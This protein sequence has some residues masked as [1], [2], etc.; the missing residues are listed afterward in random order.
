MANTDEARTDE[1]DAPVRATDRSPFVAVLLG[2]V[3]AGGLGY[4][5]A[6][7]TEFGLFDVDRGAD[8][9][10]SALSGDLQAQG[11]RLDELAAALEVA[12]QGESG[13]DALGQSIDDTSEQMTALSDR[14]AALEG[15][16]AGGSDDEAV[17]EGIAAL[18]NDLDAQLAALS[19]AIE[20]LES[21]PGQDR[22]DELAQRL[23]ALAPLTDSVAALE[24]RPAAA[25][26]ERVDELAARIDEL[27]GRLDS[28]SG[29]I[30]N[31]AAAAEAEAA[32]I[33]AQ[34][35]VAEIRA[36]LNRGRP[37]ADALA[38]FR[39][40]SDAEAPEGL[41]RSAEEGVA[42]L[43]ALQSDFP[44]AARAALSRSLAETTGDS[45]TGRIGAFLQAQTG[46]RSLNERE[47]DGPDAVLSR[48]EARL[49]EGEIGA[50]LSEIE[51]LPE[52]GREAL[53]DWTTRARARADAI[54]GLESLAQTLNSN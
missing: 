2:G 24:A 37:Y 19:D 36:A 23:D 6:Y 44:P 17:R 50:A 33:A 43:A 10:L 35:A 27:A 3:L 7:Y 51:A 45:M 47:G 40:A 26:V 8:D 41:S 54:A 5:A 31:A 22:F 11:A 53:G 18:R 20:T 16:P 25:T 30:E 13:L 28:Q 34:G 32:R 52:A 42:T 4:I 46:A 38:Q 29:Q 12:G 21:R 1:Q 48:A 9:R 14:L 15:A 49:A 39:Q